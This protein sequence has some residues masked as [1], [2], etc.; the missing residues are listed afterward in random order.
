[1]T[2]ITGERTAGS[3]TYFRPAP[4]TDT[5]TLRATRVGGLFV[6]CRHFSEIVLASV[7]A[8]TRVQCRAVLS[9]R[10]P[11]ID[12]VDLLDGREVDANQCLELTRAARMR[13][14]SAVE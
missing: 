10:V 9:N 12:F 11:P 4:P 7:V 5:P 6:V 2:I 1:M 3:F 13:A 14:L 8:D